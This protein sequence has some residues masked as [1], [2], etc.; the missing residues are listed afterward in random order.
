MSELDPGA[1][2]TTAIVDEEGHVPSAAES[3]Q[4][5]AA[6]VEQSARPGWRT[7]LAENPT[8]VLCAVVV[9]GMTSTVFPLAWQ[10]YS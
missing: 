9:M 8:L 2:G 5:V 1:T 4:V 10:M 6:I 3:T 7:R